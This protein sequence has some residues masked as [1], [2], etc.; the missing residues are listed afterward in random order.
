MDRGFWPSVSWINSFT[1][2]SNCRPETVGDSARRGGIHH[3]IAGGV[4]RVAALG[5]CDRV[6]D[7]GW[8]AWWRSHGAAYRDDENACTEAHGSSEDRDREYDGALVSVVA[9]QVG[10]IR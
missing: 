10:V 6:V 5:D 2:R 1:I 4:A 7:T 3:A 9:V 8:R